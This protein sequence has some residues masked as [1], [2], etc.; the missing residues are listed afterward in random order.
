MT[1]Y[2]DILFQMEAKEAQAYRVGKKHCH[3]WCH[4]WADS[5][6]ELI[7]FALKIGMKRQWLQNESGRFPHFDLVPPRRKRAI[8]LGAIETDLREWFRKL[9]PY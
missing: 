2:V 5:I 4:L 8:E 9:H 3:R 1:V 6:E 7:A